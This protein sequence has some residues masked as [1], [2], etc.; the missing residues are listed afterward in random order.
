MPEAAIA[1]I[2]SKEYYEKLR[3]ENVKNILAV[4][5]SYDTDRKEHQCMI[6]EI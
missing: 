3:K 5:I 4:G 2:K 1:Q 6:E